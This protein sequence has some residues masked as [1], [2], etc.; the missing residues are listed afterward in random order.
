MADWL[1]VVLPEPP[2][3]NRY[4]RIFLNRAVKSDTARAYA[5]TVSVIVR[6]KV[7]HPTAKP[8]AVSMHWYRGRRSGDVDNRA[9]VCLDA[10]QGCA[11]A[12]D[13]QVTELHMYRHDDKS[14]PRMEVTIR[15]I[16]A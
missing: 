8:V 2:S 3:S 7:K 4:W 11:F 9:K 12:N 5:S 1:H 13:N 6:G 14:N 15:E 10:L 16:A